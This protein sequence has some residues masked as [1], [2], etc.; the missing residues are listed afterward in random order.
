MI[1]WYLSVRKLLR[2]IEQKSGDALAL[3][4]QGGKEA[5]AQ[6]NAYLKADYDKLKTLWAEQLKGSV[7]SYLWRHISFGMDGDYRDILKQDLAEVEAKAEAL[8]LAGSKQQAPLGFENLLNPIIKQNCYALY[9]EGHL[10]EAVLNSITAVFDRIHGLTKIELDG[11]K[12]VDKALSVEKPFLILSDLD[13]ESGRNDQAGFMQILK[14]AFQGIRNPK[15]HSLDHDLTEEKA[16][17]YL[18]FASLLARRIDEAKIV[19]KG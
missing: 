5:A 16:A 4:E 11:A 3:Y 6:V 17:Q 2:D 8:L 9:R 13:S 15:A 12:L 19:K 18:I 7:P 14:G 1:Q 10:R